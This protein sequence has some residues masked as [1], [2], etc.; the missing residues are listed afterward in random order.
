MNISVGQHY[1][2][3]SYIAN[4]YACT[5]FNLLSNREL[6]STDYCTTEMYYNYVCVLVN[7]IISSVLRGE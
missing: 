5:G 1:I 3:A 6:G 2:I 7:S 4:L